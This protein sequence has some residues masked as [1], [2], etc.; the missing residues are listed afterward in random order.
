[1]LRLLALE[2]PEAAALVELG[3]NHEQQHQ[4]LILMDIKHALSL[5]PLLPAYR[6]APPAMRRRA[7]PL[8]WLDFPG[9]LAEIGHDGTNNDG[10]GFAFDNEGPRHRIWLEPFRLASRP[11]TV[12]EYLGFIEDGGYERPEFWLSDGWATCRRE[13]WQAPLYWLAEADGWSVFTLSGRRNLDPAEPVC[14]VSH[15]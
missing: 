9:G 3:L 13:G 14:H 10:A 2:R 1:M 8:E 15:C 12:G 11:V 7:P 4:E 5:N 6:E